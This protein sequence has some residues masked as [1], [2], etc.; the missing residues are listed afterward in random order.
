MKL[1]QI[2]AAIKALVAEGVDRQTGEISDQLA[3]ELDA[4]RIEEQDKIESIALYIK[5]L[6]AEA[7]AI[8]VEEKALAARRKAKLNKSRWLT[9]YLG[10]YLQREER[11]DFETPRCRLSFRRSEAVEVTDEDA[12]RTW[13]AGHDDYLRYREPELDKTALKQALKAGQAIPGAAL[14]ERMNLQIK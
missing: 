3:A 14:A 5:N 1:Y 13:L 7:E 2:P 4:L 12:L 11:A 10:D 6:Q 8:A 9:G